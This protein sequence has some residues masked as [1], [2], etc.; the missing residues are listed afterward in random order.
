MRVRRGEYQAS[1]SIVASTVPW[2]TVDNLS[3][4]DE[5]PFLGRLATDS[6]RFGCSARPCIYAT[7]SGGLKTTAKDPRVLPSTVIYDQSLTISLP[8][9]LSVTSGINAIA[10][11]A[12][13]LY[14]RDTNLVMDIFAESGIRSLS[15]ALPKI[16]CDA[17]DINVRSDALYGSSMCGSVLGNFSMSIHHKLCRHSAAVSVYRTPNCIQSSCRMRRGSRL[18]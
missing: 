15:V 8:T 4:R 6:M 11:A 18:L 10:H 3:T 5:R 2:W 1:T 7:A 16:V 12:Q 13:G 17:S 14:A 9:G